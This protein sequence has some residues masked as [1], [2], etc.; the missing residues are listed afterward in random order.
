MLVSAAIALFNFNR[1]YDT[2]AIF[3]NS[4]RRTTIITTVEGDRFELDNAE[5]DS[6]TG[7]L[8]YNVPEAEKRRADQRRDRI[9]MKMWEDYQEYLQNLQ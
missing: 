7:N 3:R 8:H 9:A 5:D 1:Q 2:R 4:A 6:Y